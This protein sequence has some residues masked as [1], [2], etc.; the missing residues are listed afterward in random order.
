MPVEEKRLPIVIRRL[1]LERP[2]K[3]YDGQCG[4]REDIIQRN[5]GRSSLAFSEHPQ[6]RRVYPHP[7]VYRS[8]LREHRPNKKDEEAEEVLMRHAREVLAKNAYDPEE[9][10]VD[11]ALRLVEEH[12]KR[13][14]N[15]RV[16]FFRKS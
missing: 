15:D 4:A 12:H 6:Y 3:C 14:V 5:I 9:R 2:V 13:R 7:E 10:E 16:E 11:Q 1:T 8:A